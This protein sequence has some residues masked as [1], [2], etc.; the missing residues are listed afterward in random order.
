MLSDDERMFPKKLGVLRDVERALQAV[1]VGEHNV[2]RPDGNGVG[3]SG[4]CITVVL[5]TN[6]APPAR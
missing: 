6:D 5:E 2:A 1:T 3:L 4:R